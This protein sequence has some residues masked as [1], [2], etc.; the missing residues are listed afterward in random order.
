MRRFLDSLL[1]RSRPAPPTIERLF[2]ISTAQISLETQLNLKADDH[3]GIVF[4]PV[5]SSYFEQATKDLDELLKISTNDTGTTF[6]TMTDEYRFKWIVLDDPQPEDL[7][8]TIHVIS[9][10]LIENLFGEQLLASVFRYNTAANEPLYWFYN[11]KRGTFYPFAPLPNGQKRD[12]AL[13][14]RVSSAMEH[15]LPVEK[16][17]ERWY[18]MWDIPF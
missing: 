11:Y 18:P 4:R 15:E 8:A 17:L 10:T 6:T 16:E 3:A 2:A 1:G 12:N 14:L 13:E 5:D 9:Q 7:V